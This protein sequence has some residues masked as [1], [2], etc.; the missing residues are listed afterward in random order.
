MMAISSAAMSVIDALAV[1]IDEGTAGENEYEAA[2]SIMLASH[3]MRI[4]LERF[5]YDSVRYEKNAGCVA[6][7]GEPEGEDPG[8]G[9]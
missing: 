4:A 9:A 3:A 1:K 5:G 8:E 2:M 6:E 7:F